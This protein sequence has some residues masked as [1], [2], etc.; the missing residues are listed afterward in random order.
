MPTGRSTSRNTRGWFSRDN[1]RAFGLCLFFGSALVVALGT[2]FPHAPT[3]LLRGAYSWGGTAPSTQNDDELATGSIIFVP[4]M[5][6]V[7]RKRLIDN[8]TWRIRDI[9][10]VECRKALNPNAAE[11]GL[12]LARVEV[13]RNSFSKR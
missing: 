7:C 12:S 10:F 6:N 5:G 3:A 2:V 11:S 1:R 9:G 8:A 13:I 4:I